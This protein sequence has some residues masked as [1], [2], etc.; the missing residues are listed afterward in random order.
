MRLIELLLILLIYA[1]S[2]NDK[3]VQLVTKILS[4]TQFYH[5]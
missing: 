5:G 1:I 2:P 3:H 4:M